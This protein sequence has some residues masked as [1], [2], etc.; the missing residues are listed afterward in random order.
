ML[1]GRDD[2][3][4]PARRAALYGIC[5]IAGLLA[6]GPRA[7]AGES[8]AEDR[9]FR[10]FDATKYIRKP[11]LSILGLRPIHIAYEPSLFRTQ[12]R[13][14]RTAD[15]MP[16]D[17]LL[18]EQLRE[19]RAKNSDYFILDIEA[20]SVSRSRMY[21]LETAKNIRK[22]SQVV[23]RCRVLSPATR[24]GLFGIL[25][26]SSG[27]ERLIAQAGDALH[28]EMVEDNDNLRPLAQEVDAL[29][30]VGYTMTTDPQEWRFSVSKQ[31][32]E[33]RRLSTRP[34]LLFLWPQYADY[35][36]TPDGLRRTWIA[37]EYWNFQ[38]EVARDLADGVVL[39]GGWADDHR[40]MVWDASAPWWNVTRQL[41]GAI[42]ARRSAPNRA[43]FD[44]RWW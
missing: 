13:R 22:H 7:Y 1:G 33:A 4:D 21:P 31:I 3:A 30:P 25:P 27:Y 14:M 10:V 18:A 38:L 29:F 42:T 11:N 19:A 12:S 17:G 44:V 20:W 28:R 35:G 9:A 37:P 16:S 2:G 32:A 5:S 39:W 34:V 15:E 24:L 8:A 6:S 23:D 36:P 40:P 26:T 43:S 41:L